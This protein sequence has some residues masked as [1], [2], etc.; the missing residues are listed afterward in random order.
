MKNESKTATTGRRLIKNAQARLA[1][2]QPVAVTSQDEALKIKTPE[3]ELPITARLDR[4]EQSLAEISE[5]I[6][7]LLK[8]NAVLD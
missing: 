3:E 4:V 8:R 2:H 6:A 1:E 7:R 5:G